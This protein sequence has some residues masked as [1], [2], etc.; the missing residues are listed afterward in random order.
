[1]KNLKLILGC[2]LALSLFGLSLLVNNGNVS[3][4]SQSG[5][6][7]KV[8]IN[9]GSN[10]CTWS[11]QD[12]TVFVFGTAATDT[13]ATWRNATWFAEST[14]LKSGWTCSISW[15]NLTNE[16]GNQITSGNITRTS[17]SN[18]P[19]PHNQGLTT[20]V[21]SPIATGGTIMNHTA[22]AWNI[23]HTI[24][25]NLNIPAYTVAG[26]YTWTITLDCTGC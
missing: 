14:W 20:F 8:V 26:T 3:A 5:V 23:E 9:P 16:N 12:T 10:H 7:A 17:I 15:W 22:W 25:L 19:D 24:G 18:T 21:N 11:G 1:M 13:I 6:W 2:A 4:Q